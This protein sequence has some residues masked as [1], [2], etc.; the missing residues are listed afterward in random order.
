MQHHEVISRTTD[1][2]KEQEASGNWPSVVNPTPDGAGTVDSR[3]DGVSMAGTTE[4]GAPQDTPA[5]DFRKPET[6]GL[7]LVL[8]GQV[9]V[10]AFDGAV[11]AIAAS[12]DQAMEQKGSDSGPLPG[13]KEDKSLLELFN[14]WKVS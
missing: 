10:E 1:V 11:K 14:F 4:E 7:G 5:F 12:V 9:V 3:A 13:D 6:I 8:F 2:E